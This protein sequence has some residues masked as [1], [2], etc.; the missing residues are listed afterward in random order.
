MYLT[1]ITSLRR[2]FT[3]LSFGLNVRDCML[4]CFSKRLGGLTQ[5]FDSY[6]RYELEANNAILAEDKHKSM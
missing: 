4:L 5:I 3:V 1:F 2:I 6:S